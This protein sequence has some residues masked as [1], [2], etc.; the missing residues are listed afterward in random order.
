MDKLLDFILREMTQNHGCH[1]VI[2]YGS[3]ARGDVSEESDYD[4][5]GFRSEGEKFRDARNI[6]GKF[7]DAFI[8]PES[9]LAGH[10]E[11]FLRARGGKILAQRSNFATELLLRLETI[12]N[13]GPKDLPQDEFQ[14][15]RVWIEKMLTRIRKGDIEGNYRR[16]WLQFNLLEDYF[17]FR[18]L[19]YRGPKESFLWLKEH[20]PQAYRLF[21]DA[22]SSD[23]M[24]ESLQK[25]GR[26]VAS[27]TK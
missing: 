4:V 10:E 16:L 17:A 8:Y 24:L 22:L 25:L 9:D 23:F 14:A 21:N 6:E 5:M 7:L 12:F 15:R 19:W 3:R 13:A 26:Y 11:D 27:T 2:L 20:D 18:K 1:T